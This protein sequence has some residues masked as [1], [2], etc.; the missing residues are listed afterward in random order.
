ME[1][2]MC[3][4]VALPVLALIT[5][6]LFGCGQ[7]SSPPVVPVAAPV[8]AP[9]KGVDD[10]AEI[11]KS[12]NE[13][14]KSSGP[15]PSGTN[16]GVVQVGSRRIKTIMDVIV[17]TVVQDERAVVSFGGRKLAVEFDKG[18]VL[19]DDTERA[20]LPAG[21]KEVEIQFLGGK[22]SVTADGAAVTI[23]DATQ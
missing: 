16:V 12:I 6:L 8:P 20:K 15:A 5:P 21:T 9:Q 1:L 23:P 22:L 19:L 14:I 13:S 17:S 3:K 18:R 7:T 4:Q 2:S 11:L 10:A